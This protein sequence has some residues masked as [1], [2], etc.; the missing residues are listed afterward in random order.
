VFFYSNAKRW[1]RIEFD[2]RCSLQINGLAGQ[3]LEPWVAGDPD[4]TGFFEMV[5][6]VWSATVVNASG[7]P[8][9][10]LFLSAE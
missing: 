5:G 1:I 3:T 2:Q 7:S 9:N 4:N 10:F 8:L 6:P